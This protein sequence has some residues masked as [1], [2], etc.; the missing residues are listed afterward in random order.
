MKVCKPTIEIERELRTQEADSKER[1]RARA[2][3]SREIRSESVSSERQR[4]RC[5]INRCSGF[6]WARTKDS[7]GNV[8]R[9][10]TDR[11]KLKIGTKEVRPNE[12]RPKNGWRSDNPGGSRRLDIVW[13]AIQVAPNR[14][15]RSPSATLIK[16]RSYR[17]ID[18]SIDRGI[19]GI[20]LV[21][22]CYSPHLPHLLLASL[23]ADV[24]SL[25]IILLL[26]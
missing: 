26:G 22:L 14:E 24:T 20:S 16:G 17:S 21:T 13:P 4:A 9:I 10:R 12:T 11:D 8:L 2:R 5:A 18:R 19:S 7:A 1:E 25:T 15:R 3:L 6:C 23:P